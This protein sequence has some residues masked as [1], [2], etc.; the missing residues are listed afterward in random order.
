MDG[1][2]EFTR[3]GDITVIVKAYLVFE[4]VMGKQ[5]VP[6]NGDIC[7]AYYNID[8]EAW[9]IM[10]W[11]DF[12][13]AWTQELLATDFACSLDP[14]VV[15]ARVTYRTQ[16]ARKDDRFYV[17]CAPQVIVKPMEVG[18][19]AGT[20]NVDIYEV[21]VNNPTD[22]EK[23]WYITMEKVTGGIDPTSWMKFNNHV[24]DDERCSEITVPVC[25]TR[26]DIAHLNNA[27][28]RGSY[29][30]KFLVK[31]ECIGAGIAGRAAML[32][33]YME[34][35]PELSLIA[36]IIGMS[37]AALIFSRKNSKL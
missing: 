32:N 26:S 15:T 35:V 27:A 22:S 12:Q 24:A 25:E 9:N 20:E 31:N 4:D 28:R 3:C 10:E 37:G 14:Y 30:I 13:A 21:I 33:I 23:R 6:C 17:T 34:S 18:L 29:Q 19:A 5:R 16:E 11:K 7:T 36:L 2:P 8:G 1:D